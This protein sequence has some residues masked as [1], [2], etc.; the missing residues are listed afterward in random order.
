MGA[1]EAWLHHGGL[2]KLELVSLPDTIAP[3][4]SG[5]CGP[6]VG[7]DGDGDG[8]CQAGCVPGGG[9]RL[10]ALSALNWFAFC[11][12]LAGR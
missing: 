11:Q 9:G 1:E 3:E 8:V 2:R 4:E 10:P 12:L 7:G 6:G 5:G